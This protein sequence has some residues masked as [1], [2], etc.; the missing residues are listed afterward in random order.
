MG[1]INGSGGTKE[2]TLAN[3]DAALRM[4]KANPAIKFAE[5]ARRLKLSSSAISKWKSEDIYGW[6]ARYQQALKEAFSELEG[7]AIQTMGKLIDEGNFQAS[8]YVLDNK[9]YGATQKI[10]ANINGDITINVSIEE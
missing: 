7:P 8:K 9:N 3:Q 5:I 1:K 10:D 6:S 2:I 4:I